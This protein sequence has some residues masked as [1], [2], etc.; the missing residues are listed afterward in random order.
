MIICGDCLAEMAKMEPNS[1][2][3][4]VTDL[5]VGI[6]AEHLVCADLILSGMRA[7]LS[8]QNCPYDVAVELGERL[9]RIQVKATRAPR[10]IP[11]RRGH[12]SAYLFHT[13]RA[14]KRGKRQYKNGEFDLLAL[15]ALDIRAVGYI[16]L[17]DVR[18]TVFVRIPGVSYGAKN[19]IG[20]T[21][22]SLTFQEA[23]KCLK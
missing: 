6:A 12:Q 13:R 18:D 21:F 5:S 16:P 2:D 3:A 11:Q 14:G 19:G 8:A 1:V 10:K 22:D 15:V 17:M 7:F 23:I 4:I 20:K 9:I